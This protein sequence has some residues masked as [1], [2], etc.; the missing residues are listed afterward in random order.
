MLCDSGNQALIDFFFLVP[1][2]HNTCYPR[3]DPTVIMCVLSTDHNKCLL[4]RKTGWPK[5]QYS[6]LAGFMEP[7]ESIEETVVRETKEES[8]ENNYI[9]NKILEFLCRYLKKYILIQFLTSL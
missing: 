5:K 6:C 9:G 7:G 8:G 3:T 1:G 4:G 2:V